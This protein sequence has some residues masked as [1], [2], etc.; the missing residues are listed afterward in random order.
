V[1]VTD[2]DVPERPPLATVAP[3][4]RAAQRSEARPA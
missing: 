4:V 2:V 1:V 3:N